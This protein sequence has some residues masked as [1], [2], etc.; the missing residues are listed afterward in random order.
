[1]FKH[2]SF[3]FAMKNNSCFLYFFN[4][5]RSF[6]KTFIFSSDLVLLRKIFK[7]NLSSLN[8]LCNLGL[9]ETKSLVKGFNFLGWKSLKFSPSLYMGIISI[10]NLSSYKF[11]LK[12][13]IQTICLK[14]L[15]SGLDLLNKEIYSWS[16]FHSFSDNAKNVFK[17][18]DFYVYLLIWR[19][20]KKRH[21]RRPN[22]WI[23]SKY[24]KNLANVWHFTLYDPIKKKF[25]VL[26]RHYCTS[27]KLYKLPYSYNYFEYLDY[28]RINY[29]WF[30]KFRFFND[31]IYS[32]LWQKQF[33]LCFRCLNLFEFHEIKQLKFVTMKYFNVSE[34]KIKNI[35]LIHDFCF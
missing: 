17:K 19:F 25:F 11:K 12:F 14:N 6:N 23:Y 2:L 26:Q 9:E 20:F 24:W 35:Y 18:L 33:G 22:T 10:D 8:Y 28:K 7:S 34:N 32:L 27:Y 30:N 5:F 1:M 29:L 4:Y 13:I 15:F 3:D 21:P 31:D 16:S